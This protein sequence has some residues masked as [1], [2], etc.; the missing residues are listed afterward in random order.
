ML[1]Q[2][3][4]RNRK[5]FPADFMFRLTK[6]EYAFLRSQF[7]TLERGKGKYPKYRSYVFTEQGVAMLSSVLNSDR[8]IAV[9]IQIMRVFTRVGEIIGVHKGILLKM[10]QL[11][12]TIMQHDKK[13]KKQKEEIKLVFKTIKQL[14]NPSE[15]SG[16]RI[17]Y[18][19]KG[20]RD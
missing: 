20:G 10:E 16:K 18:R 8:A 15:F 3:V 14:L 7:V 12:R 4:K 9:N 19:L 2:A 1:N 17:G 13:F 11:E 6:S 5:R